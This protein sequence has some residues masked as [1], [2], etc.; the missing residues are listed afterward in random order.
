MGGLCVDLSGGEALLKKGIEEV[1][2]TA[3][4]QKLRTFVL[5]NAID[6]NQKQLQRISPYIDGITVGLD[7][8]DNSNDYIRG[9]GSFE[10]TVSGLEK[11]A[12]M[13]IELSLTTLI[14]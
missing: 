6:L 3:R 7:G 8:L 5:S 2:K 12:N 10:K 1:I 14:T 11:I 9:K 4:N 13:G